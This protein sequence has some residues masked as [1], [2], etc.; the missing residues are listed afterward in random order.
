MKQNEQNNLD[1]YRRMLDKINEAKKLNNN[2]FSENQN[3]S[4]F[5]NNYSYFQNN[6]N[7]SLFSNNQSN[8]ETYSK[9][10]NEFNNNNN[11]RKYINFDI[12]Q[13]NQ[14]QIKNNG[15]TVSDKV[16]FG[17]NYFPN[18]HQHKELNKTDNIINLNNQHNPLKNKDN[19][20]PPKNNNENES[21]DDDYIPENSGNKLNDNILNPKPKD[22]DKHNEQQDCIVDVKNDDKDNISQKD[23]KSF[24][25]LIYGLALGAFG[26]FLLWCQNKS[27]R[28]YIK[29]NYRNINLE[30]ILNFFKRFLHPIELFNSLRNSFSNL[31]SVLKDSLQYIYRFIDNNADLWRYLGIILAIFVIWIVIKNLFKFVTRGKKHHH[32]KKIAY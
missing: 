14:N 32:K 25:S 30:S 1:T 19:F 6:N 3:R 2:S 4:T 15:Q 28:E 26:T 9:T 20:Y 27:F 29:T 21:D 10:G 12:N 16:F 11:R 18:N 23:S 22:E 13:F 8:V 17:D 24:P 31:S 7:N 5:E